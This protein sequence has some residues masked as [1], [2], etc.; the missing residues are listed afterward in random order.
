MYYLDRLVGRE[1]F[2]KFIPFYFTKWTNKSL[3]SFEFRDTF[4]EFF[5]TPEY[6][7]LKDKLASIDWEGRFFTPGLPPKPE[8][9]TSLADVCYALAKKWEKSDFSPSPKDI[10][11][12]TGNQVLLLLETVLGFEKPLTAEQVVCYSPSSNFNRER[13]KLDG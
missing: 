1:N 6:A 3:D 2:N 12:W 8:F 7:D 5:N 10:S 9:D 4:L 13:P 11:S